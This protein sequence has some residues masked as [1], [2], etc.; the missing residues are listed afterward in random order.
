MDQQPMPEIVRGRIT[1]KFGLAIALVIAGLLATW[2]AP[3]A[4]ACQGGRLPASRLTVRAPAPTDGDL[5]DQRNRAR[6]HVQPV[7]ANL[8]LRDVAARRTPTRWSPRT[9]SPTGATE[10][11]PPGRPT[12]AT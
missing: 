9:A 3:S 12:P 7:Y 11:L 4:L 2:E 5:P 10:P 1:P 8:P 6:H